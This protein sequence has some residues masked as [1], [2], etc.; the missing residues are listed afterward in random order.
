M[1][2]DAAPQRHGIVPTHALHCAKDP[3][4]TV[5]SGQ[6]PNPGPIRVLPLA[7][8][9]DHPICFPSCFVV[10]AKE[11]VQ[12][13]DWRRFRHSLMS[14]RLRWPLNSSTEQA[15]MQGLGVLAK[16]T[17]FGIVSPNSTERSLTLRL[18]YDHI[19]KV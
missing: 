18:K 3:S 13:F 7:D 17:E 8:G 9:R 4:Q 12:A 1:G 16:T 19:D 6:H 14:E 11:G 5:F 15:V 10:F 2:N